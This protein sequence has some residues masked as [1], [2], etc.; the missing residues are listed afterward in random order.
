MEISEH[1]GPAWREIPS[2]WM[3]YFQVKDADERALRAVALGARTVAPPRDIPQVGRF[4][5]L[6]DPQGAVFSIFQAKV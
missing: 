1:G 5:A 4:A 6:E 3:V 2:H